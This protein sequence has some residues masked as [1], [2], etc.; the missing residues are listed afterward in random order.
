MSKRTPRQLEMDASFDAELQ[1][2]IRE[3]GMSESATVEFILP[4]A[5]EDVRDSAT[6]KCRI[7]VPCR[8][9]LLQITCYGPSKLEYRINWKNG[10][11]SSSL[12]PGEKR[13]PFASFSPSSASGPVILLSRCIPGSRLINHTQ[14]S[15]WISTELGTKYRLHLPVGYNRC[16]ISVQLDRAIGRMTFPVACVYDFVKIEPIAEEEKVA[17]SKEEFVSN[18]IGWHSDAFLEKRYPA[19]PVDTNEPNSPSPSA[20]LQSSPVQLREEDGCGYT[21]SLPDMDTTAIGILPP[22]CVDVE[23][24]SVP[25]EPEPQF[26]TLP[27]LPDLPG[28]ED[29]EEMDRR[30]Y[31]TDAIQRVWAMEEEIERPAFWDPSPPILPYK[32]DSVE[33][34]DQYTDQL[35][36]GSPVVDSDSYLLTF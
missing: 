7:R 13:I 11:H 2:R 8:P 25:M 30:S 19:S 33:S 26:P 36:I 17:E 29:Q 12:V 21:P 5:I 18:E 6:V 31:L 23:L 22:I 14:L 15:T 16:D 24:E 20:H 34:H 9:Q 1:K 4:M 10:S 28:F 27:L 35:L 32:C 3:S